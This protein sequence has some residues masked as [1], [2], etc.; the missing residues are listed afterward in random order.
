MHTAQ[1]V[2]SQQRMAIS[3]FAQ[4]HLLFDWTSAVFAAHGCLAVAAA[5]FLGYTCILL[6]CD[7]CISGLYDRLSS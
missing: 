2:L 1:R 5:V 3:N 4:A 7:W 6:L